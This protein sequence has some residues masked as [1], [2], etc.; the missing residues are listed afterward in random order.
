MTETPEEE[1]ICVVRTTK[2]DANSVEVAVE[3]TSIT[4]VKS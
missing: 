1:P 3:S 2:V 4:A